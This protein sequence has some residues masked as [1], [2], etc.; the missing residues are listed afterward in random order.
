M[1]QGVI[2]QRPVRPGIVS[3]IPGQFGCLDLQNAMWVE[4]SVA[5]T[6]KP[7]NLDGVRVSIDLMAEAVSAIIAFQAILNISKNK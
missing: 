3:H 2:A 4:L 5:E 6:K 7:A 1:R